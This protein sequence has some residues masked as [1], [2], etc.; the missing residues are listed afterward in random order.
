MTPIDDVA[1][2]A[3][4]RETPEMRATHAA[5]H[6]PY[7]HGSVNAELDRRASLIRDLQAQVHELE[8]RNRML[9]GA[10]R[11]CVAVLERRCPGGVGPEAYGA[12]MATAPS[13]C[14]AVLGR[15]QAGLQ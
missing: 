6:G 5:K 8:R 15:T 2:P 11:D 13:L 12:I 9:T 10:L 4:T 7:L 14:A 1:Q 3:Q